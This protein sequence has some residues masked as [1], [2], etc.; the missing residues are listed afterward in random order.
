MSYIKEF[1]EVYKGVVPEYNQMVEELTNGPCIALEVR[2][3]NVVPALREL[4]GPHDP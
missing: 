1:L 3:E 2:H 4:C